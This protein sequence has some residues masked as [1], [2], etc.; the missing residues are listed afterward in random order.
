MN[1]RNL[2]VNILILANSLYACLYSLLISLVFNYMLG[3]FY[4][5]IK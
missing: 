4:V 5:L 3:K 1:V 2:I